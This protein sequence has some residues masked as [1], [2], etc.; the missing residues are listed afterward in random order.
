[1]KF[2]DMHCDTLTVCADMKGDL[3][4]CGLQTSLEKLITSGYI[5]Q[6]F[7]VFTEG[8]T[9]ALDFE[10]YLAFYKNALSV[11]G[12]IVAP[13]LSCKDIEICGREGKLG[14]ILSVENLSFTGGD[15]RRLSALKEVGVK[16]ASLVWNNENAFARPNLIMRGGLPQFEKREER[17]LTPLGREAAERLDELKIIIDISH[18]SDGGANELLQGRKIPLAASHSNAAGVCGVSRNLTDGLI[19]KIADCGGVI[20]VNFCADFLGGEA[21][22]SVLRHIKYL[23]NAGGENVVALGSD[24]DGIPEV[25]NLEDCTRVPA[26]F[27]YLNKNG[28]SY[29]TLEKISHKNFLRVFSQFD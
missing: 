12:D 26:L 7:A 17:G 4:V 11:H 23:I 6:C 1:M 15:M 5:A 29:N 9:A 22:E 20:G 28:V 10:R 19:K 13:V 27:E 16:M 18:L 2:I 21:F 3:A 14:C 25:E 8:E 24:F